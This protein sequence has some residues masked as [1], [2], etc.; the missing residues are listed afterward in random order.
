[1]VLLT[2][3]VHSQNSKT[4]DSTTI[5][6]SQLRAAL[7]LVEQGKHCAEVLALTQKQIELLNAKIDIK[8][9]IIATVYARLAIAADVKQTYI[10]DIKIYEVENKS[11]NSQIAQLQKSVKK[12]KRK[13]TFSRITTLGLAAV[14]GYIILK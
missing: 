7:K 3:C 1:M 13:T 4:S 2:L 11:L 6:N 14:A 10:N 8:D 5:P 9:S 12:Q